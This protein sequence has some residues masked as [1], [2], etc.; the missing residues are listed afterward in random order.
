MTQWSMPFLFF[1]VLLLAGLTFTVLND[2]YIRRRHRKAMLGIIALC[3]SLIAQNY[4]ESLLAAGAPRILARTAVSMYGYCARPAVIALFFSIVAPKRRFAG[5]WLMVGANAAV[6]CTALFSP[7]C[8]FIDSD[9]H[10]H[11]GPLRNTCLIVSILLL[12][13]L[14][15]LTVREYARA[16][17][18][19]IAIPALIVATILTAIWLDGRV[20]YQEQPVTYLT[21]AMAV[22]CLLFYIWLHMQFV[23]E[24]EED[25]KARQ[26]IRIMMSQIQPHFLYNTLSTIQVLCHTDPEKAADIT[27]SFSAYLRLNLDALGQTGLIPFRKELEHTRL[28]ARIEMTRFPNVRVEY[29]IRD[30]DFSLPPLTLQPMV[31][32]AI[33]YGVRI[34]EEGVVRVS[35]RRT[36]NCHEIVIRDNGVGF[37]V[38]KLAEMDGSH[39]GIRNVRERLESMCGGA[40]MIDSRI[41]EGTAVT[42]R[43]PVREESGWEAKA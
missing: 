39:I 3:V 32:N 18:R 36:E 21:V 30:E 28:Y 25:L 31:E 17:R 7:V 1:V 26:R 20:G 29:D 43:L 42:L 9:N 41:G 37:D 15:V 35:A 5:A 19:E 27:G 16:P 6:Y 33:R 10:F 40:L 11:A 8:F 24:H 12:I 34:R 38:K 22:S 2:P 14:L 23:R 4:V 13:C